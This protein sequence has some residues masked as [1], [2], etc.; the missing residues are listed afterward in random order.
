MSGSS[1]AI[2]SITYNL[3]DLEDFNKNKKRKQQSDI[4]QFGIQ[5]VTKQ[6]QMKFDK[7]IAM[8]FYKTNTSFVFSFLSV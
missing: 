1:E 5:P 2:S 6:E 7:A 4:R 8:H 3:N